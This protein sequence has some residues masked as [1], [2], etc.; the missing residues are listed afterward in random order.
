MLLAALALALGA[1]ACAE[2]SAGQ[3]RA[4]VPG[5]SVTDFDR[6]PTNSRP[7]SSSASPLGTRGIP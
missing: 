4:I 5:F 6:G 1:S 3:H 7:E 2:S